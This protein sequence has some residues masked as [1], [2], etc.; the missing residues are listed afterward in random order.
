MYFTNHFKIIREYNIEICICVLSN[1]STYLIILTRLSHVA[2]LTFFSLIFITKSPGN[3]PA[4]SAIESFDVK[5][6]EQKLDMWK[7]AK[8]SLISPLKFVRSI[9][10]QLYLFIFPPSNFYGHLIVLLL[11]NKIDFIDWLN[12]FN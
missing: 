12:R 4:C 1:S 10:T 7:F 8:K 5:E 2:R 3:K 11:C 6:I 9:R